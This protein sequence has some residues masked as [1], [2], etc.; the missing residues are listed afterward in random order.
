[1]LLN[2]KLPDPI[3]DTKLSCQILGVYSVHSDIPNEQLDLKF[4]GSMG[5]SYLPSFWTPNQ[6][7]DPWRVHSEQNNQAKDK[8]I[9]VDTLIFLA[10]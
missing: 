9:G 5:V 10:V 1:M 3:L 2:T 7:F 8:I 4:M 6:S